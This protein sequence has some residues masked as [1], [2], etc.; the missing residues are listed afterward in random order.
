[1]KLGFDFAYN[2]VC[3]VALSNAKSEDREKAQPHDFDQRKPLDDLGWDEIYGGYA[4]TLEY[5]SIQWALRGDYVYGLDATIDDERLPIRVRIS[6]TE[7]RGKMLLWEVFISRG[8]SLA[9]RSM[10]AS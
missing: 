1:M 6:R 10:G 2:P 3:F 4:Q 7:Y 9:R 8:E 5:L